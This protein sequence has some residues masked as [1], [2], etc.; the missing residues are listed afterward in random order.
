MRQHLKITV[1]R[2][3]AASGGAPR[4]AASGGLWL[5]AAVSL[6]AVAVSL[7]MTPIANAGNCPNEAIRAEQGSTMLP[8]CRAYE[9]VTPPSKDSDGL[10]E[11]TAVSPNGS[12]LLLGSDA[13]F[14]G[15]EANTGIVDSSRYSMRRTESGWVT[16]PQDPPAS[17]FSP[18]LKEGKYTS[19]FAGTSEDGLTTLWTDQGATRPNNSIDFYVRRPNGSIVDV[20]PIL[21]PSAPP[22]V[23]NEGSTQLNIE[24]SGISADASRVLFRFIGPS[25][26]FAET[27]AESLPLYEYVGTGNTE[28]LLV[29]VGN[30][31]REIS[32]CGTSLGAGITDTENG[33]IEIESSHDAISAD[34]NTV[35]FTA[36]GCVPPTPGPPVNELFAR[37]DNG[38]AGAHTVA[39]SEPSKQDCSSCD[40]E[41]NV[42][43]GAKFE[44]ASEDGSRVFFSTE[45]PLLNGAGGLYEYDFNAPEGERV[46][47]VASGGNVLKV[48]EDGSHVYFSSNAVLGVLPNR[49]GQYAQPGV[50]NVYVYDTGTRQSRS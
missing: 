11:I 49:E 23:L 29:G 20:G 6:S 39:L 41:N 36:S 21:P 28:P 42:L 34:G 10:W 32:Q 26:P 3:G 43:A 1:G 50:G 35:F 8:D 25:W 47:L 5:W 15:D 2:V 37:I 4:R 17:E 48:S 12:S 45:Q 14:A 7:A 44:G 40:T 19:D 9:Q 22:Y 46:R 38:L 33:L 16:V 27:R 31:G 30:N 24:V 18:Y 13:A